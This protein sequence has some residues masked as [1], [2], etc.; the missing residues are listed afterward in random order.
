MER[1]DLMKFMLL[2]IEYTKS[3]VSKKPFKCAGN[4]SVPPQLL[5]VKQLTGPS[6]RTLCRV[7]DQKNKLG[8]VF[9]PFG[10][11]PYGSGSDSPVAVVGSLLSLGCG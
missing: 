10:Q 7:T 4:L 9:M 6:D 1:R 8:P 2:L 5:K 11:R 3:S